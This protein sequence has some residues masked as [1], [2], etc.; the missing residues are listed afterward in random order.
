MIFKDF[1][2][3]L[4]KNYQKKFLFF[5]NNAVISHTKLHFHKKLKFIL[6]NLLYKF[7]D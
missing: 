3:L 7:K 1:K 5:S 4:S 6:S 2:N